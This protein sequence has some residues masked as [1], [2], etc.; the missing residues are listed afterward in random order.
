MQPSL[1]APAS[2]NVSLGAAKLTVMF[3]QMVSRLA[4]WACAASKNRER[5]LSIA[6]SCCKAGAAC[7]CVFSGGVDGTSSRFGKVQSAEKRRIIHEQFD[8]P[9]PAGRL[10]ASAVGAAGGKGAWRDRASD[11]PHFARRRA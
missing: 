1:E 2:V 3:V 7:R 5:D 8:H 6:R 9:R 10:E 4:T 11:P